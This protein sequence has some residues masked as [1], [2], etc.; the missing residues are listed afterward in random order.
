MAVTFQPEGYATVT[1]YLMTT[2]SEAVIEFAK[3]A[4]D[5]GAGSD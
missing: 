3:Q 2:D 1:P 4:L 5:A